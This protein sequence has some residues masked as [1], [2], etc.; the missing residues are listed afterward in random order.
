MKVID[1][2]NKIANKEDI[3]LIK[4]NHRIL[5]YNYENNWFED[6]D[7]D[8]GYCKIDIAFEDLNCELEIIEEDKKIEE[9]HDSYYIYDCV[10]DK[11]DHKELQRMVQDLYEK[12][13]EIIDCINKEE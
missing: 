3:P 8:D 10:N 12:I 2:L 9:I 5:K 11:I 13:N 1:I 7:D 6:I 4:Y